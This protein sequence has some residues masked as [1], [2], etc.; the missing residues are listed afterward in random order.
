MKLVRITALGYV[1]ML[2]VSVLG[3]SDDAPSSNNPDGGSGGASTGG[4][5]AV[6]GRAGGGISNAAGSGGTAAGGVSA[7]G[8]VSAA[9]G[10]KAT[11]GGGA[12][13]ASGGRRGLAG[14]GGTAPDA[15]DASVEDSGSSLPH[16]DASGATEGGDGS[17]RPHQERLFLTHD[18][19]DGDLVGAA[20]ALG[21]SVTTG[22][23]A[24][25]ALC[26]RAATSAGLGGTW[27]AWLSDGAHDAIDR[28]K[29]VGPWYR[30]DGVA[31]FAGKAALVGNPLVPIDRDETGA[32]TEI[33]D[34]SGLA[35]IPWTGT[36]ADGT[37]SVST[38]GDWKSNSN[39][40]HGMAGANNTTTNAKWSEGTV[41][42]CNN[43]YHLYCFEQ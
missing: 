12:A 19:W 42:L 10:A 43:P 22:I 34:A 20:T 27:I 24:G 32:E 21:I 39:A 29:D 28:V 2:G 37:R 6:A 14:A 23:A 8:G 40:D 38:C 13:P 36:L 4:N 9:G 16:P 25:D 7:T 11:G 18:R 35:D 5:T 31:V 15:G 17:R 1:G 30:V 26:N 3:C 41:P 33:L